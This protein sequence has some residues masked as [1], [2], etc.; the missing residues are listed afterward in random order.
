MSITDFNG[1]LVIDSLPIKVKGLPNTINNEFGISKVCLNI[2]HGRTSDLK[3]S[4]LSPDGTIVWLT[5]RN[6]GNGK[7]YYQTCFSN[8]GFSGFIHQGKSPF[9]GEYVPDGRLTFFNNQQNPNGIWYLLV[10]DLRIGYG[11]DVEMVSL[12]FEKDPPSDPESNCSVSQSVNCTCANELS[13]CNLLPDLVMIKQ[14]TDD[15]IIEYA[16]DDKN[17]PGQLRFAASILNVGDGPLEIFG[18]NEWYCNEKKV[19]DST[20]VCRD[21]SLPKQIIYQKIYQKR[22]N[23]D[24]LTFKYIEAG[25]NYYDQ[26]PGHDHYHVDNWVEFRLLKKRKFWWNKKITASSKV[27]FCL[28]DFGICNGENICVVEGEVIDRTTLN[29]YGLGSFA[30][31]RSNKQ[32]ISVGGYDTYGVFYEGQYLDIPP[33]TKNGSYILEIEI[34]PLQLYQESNEKN[35]TLVFPVQLEKQR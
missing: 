8:T 24:S 21:G 26:K 12:E 2:T 27:S 30:G 22:K 35:N 1:E 20:S 28:F 29:N 33:N 4:L 15:Q 7:N 19:N 25:T 16:Q 13:E 32:G 18:K 3:V 31:C 5:N 34:D 11:G 6:G 14:M 17:F 10:R 23:I 9:I